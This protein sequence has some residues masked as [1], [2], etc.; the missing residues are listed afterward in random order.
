[1][2]KILSV[3]KVVRMHQ[4]VEFQAIQGDRNKNSGGEYILYLMPPQAL[5]E[6]VQLKKKMP[7]YIIAILAKRGNCLKQTI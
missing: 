7:K 6:K 1:M 3:L 5:S 2:T 4:H